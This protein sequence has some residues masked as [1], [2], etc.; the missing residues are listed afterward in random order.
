MSGAHLLT[1][2]PSAIRGSR[3]EPPGYRSTWVEVD[4][5]AIAGNVAALKSAASAPLLLA[6][7]KANGYGHGIVEAGVAAIRGGADWL[8]VA[9][10]EEAEVLRGEGITAPVLVLNE[11]TIAAIPAML[12]AGATPVAYTPEFVNALDVHARRTGDGPFAVHLK[13][14]TGMRRVGLPEADWDDALRHVRDAT[15]VRVQGLM[16]HLAVADDPG[17]PYTAEQTTAFARG[18]ELAARLGIRPEI[19]H[20]ANSAG[21]LT[22]P[23]HHYD[24]VRPGI[25]IYGLDPGEGLTDGLGLTPALTWWTRVSLVK[26]V[27]AGESIGYGRAWTAE[28]DSTI[29]TVPVGYGDGLTRALTNVGAVV[30]RGRRVLISGRVSMDQSLLVVPGAG[31]E[32]PVAVGDE[33]ALIGAQGEARVT[34]DDWARWL[35]TINYEIT[36]TIGARVP[37]VYLQADAAAPRSAPD[38]AERHD[39]GS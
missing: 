8:G 18:V 39:E 28:R 11:P 29:A 15:G 1:G 4:T 35:G 32:P 24:M 10:V 36:T 37:R 26:R 30:L 38:T 19:V 31:P 20:L 34:A 21:T 17:D 16:S 12:A 9:L 25:A 13:L 22:I 14:D 5:D 2:S 33:V 23:E 27:V 6:A 3:A 7:V